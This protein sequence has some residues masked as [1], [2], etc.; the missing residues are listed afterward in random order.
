MKHVQTLLV[1]SAFSLLLALGAAPALAQLGDGG[2][3]STT[4]TG[5]MSAGSTPGDATEGG[6][7]LQR[8]AGVTGGRFGRADVNR[9]QRIDEQEYGAES[10]TLFSG[11]DSDQNGQI[12]E[13][14]F[15]NQRARDFGEADRNTDASLG[16]DE[17]S[18]FYGSGNAGS[19][20][21]ENGSGTVFGNPEGSASP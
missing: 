12:S 6:V 7:T 13:S 21:G 1:S 19:T 3:A 14:E 16:S 11:M 10:D 15:N 5:Q 2:N 17:Y 20:T 18:S 8:E 9:D 4:T